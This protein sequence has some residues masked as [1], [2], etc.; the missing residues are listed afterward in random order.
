MLPPSSKS[1]SSADRLLAVLWRDDEREDEPI[2]GLGDGQRLVDPISMEL[3]LL[4]E[5]DG[6]GGEEG[7]DSV[8]GSLSSSLEKA[9][10]ISPRHFW[11]MALIV[12]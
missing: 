10:S 4:A 7:N 12:V 9:L 3:E 6:E 8:A 11:S 5:R 2:Q 1:L